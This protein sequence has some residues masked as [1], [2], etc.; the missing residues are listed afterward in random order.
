MTTLKIDFRF[1]YVVYSWNS[2]INVRYIV[3]EILFELFFIIITILILFIAR[4]V[5]TCISWV[6]CP[7]V[8]SVSFGLRGRIDRV[9]PALYY[10]TDR[11][12]NRPGSYRLWVSVI[13]VVCPGNVG[14]LDTFEYEFMLGRTKG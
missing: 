11:M 14:R 10:Y 9:I 5:T 8:Y 6:T 7:R 2:W 4:C 3:F 1:M 12:F 13:R